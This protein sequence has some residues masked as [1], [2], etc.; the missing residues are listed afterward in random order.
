MILSIINLLISLAIASKVFDL[1][2]DKGG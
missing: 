1:I 2:K